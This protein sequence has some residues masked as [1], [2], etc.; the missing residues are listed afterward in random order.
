MPCNAIRHIRSCAG[1]ADL[2]VLDLSYN[3]LDSDAVNALSLLP[4]LR[5]LDLTCNALTELPVSMLRFSRLE[6]LNLERN[7]LQ[8]FERI[9]A[10]VLVKFRSGSLCFYFNS[11]AMHP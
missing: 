4:K 7:R 5:A 1:F 3:A 9:S 6:T 2:E 10:A 11:R 8:V